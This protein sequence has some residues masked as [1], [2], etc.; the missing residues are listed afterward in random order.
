MKFTTALLMCSCG[1]SPQMV[2]KVTFNS[3]VFL[4]FGWSLCMVLFQYVAPDVIVQLLESSQSTLS[5]SVSS[6][7]GSNTKKW[8]LSWMKQHIMTNE[9][10][11]VV[12]WIMLL[13]IPWIY[14]LCWN[15]AV[16]YFNGM[17]SFLRLRRLTV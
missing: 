14:K 7:W 4:G 5:R 17:I 1:G 16:T 2:Y 13:M 8:R 11:K 10:W 9:N 3:S 15:M 6:A 12:S